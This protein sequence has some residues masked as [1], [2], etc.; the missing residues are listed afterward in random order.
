M[1]A[2]VRV[3]L[4]GTSLVFYAT[5]NELSMSCSID[6]DTCGPGFDVL[7]PVGRFHSMISESRA[8]F[9]VIEAGETTLR[10]ELGSADYELPTAKPEEFPIT[11][12][13]VGTSVTVNARGLR[14][15]IQQ[16]NFCT[17]VT[18][19]RYQLSGVHFDINE[20]RASFVGTDGRRLA[21]SYIVAAEQ[22]KM[23]GIIP[24]KA[25][26][27]IVGI[28]DQDGWAVIIADLNSIT[29]QV[30]GCTMTSRL[31]EGRYPNWKMVVPDVTRYVNVPFSA[32]I[33]GSS[34]RQAAIVSDKETR[35]VDMVFTQG[36]V[37]LQTATAE[38]GRSKVS[39]PVAYDG[40]L[41]SMR[42]DH[43]FAGDF[44]K[45]VEPGSMIEALFHSPTTP[46]VFRSGTGY[47]YVI[48]PMASM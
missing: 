31:V 48:M 33:L 38:T 11:K 6:C 28:C 9:V 4:E 25:T 16:T 29:V 30:G 41:L 35:G 37:T 15:A 46:M 45:A 7:L 27:S 12:P 19:N 42:I 18:S 10:V 3:R 14:K 21:H 17:D 39:L 24:L 22:V 34:L 1:L 23:T 26:K 20:G 40:D 13:T 47:E 2:N 5:D 36:E 32:D 8:D 43:K 44:C